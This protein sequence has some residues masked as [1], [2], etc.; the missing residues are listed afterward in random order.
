MTPTFLTTADLAAAGLDDSSLR[1]GARRGELERVRRGLYLPRPEWEQLGDRDRHVALIAAATHLLSKPVL[2]SHESAGALW[3]FPVLDEWPA[4]VHVLDPAR[5]TGKRTRYLVRHPGSHLSRATVSGIACTSAARTAVDIALLRG[6]TAGLLA[7]DFGLASNLV[8]LDELRAE[9]EWR[10]N[11]R[12]RRAALAAINLAD[13]RSGSAGE[14]ASRS[15]MHELGIPQ[16]ELQKRFQCSNGKTYF[17][18]FWWARSGVIGEFD[19]EQK[20]LDPELRQGRSMQ[21]VLL[22]EKDRHDALLAHPEV[23]N[24]V[25]WNYATARRPPKLAA[26]LLGAG[27]PRLRS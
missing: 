5:S 10:P 13:G 4:A 6:F 14:S 17:V 23:A 3:G 22:D 2:V 12:G 25:R 26:V 15:T 24:L 16:P 18:D 11:A 1:R 21:R 7:C 20:Y 19:G 8:S 9:L 27:V